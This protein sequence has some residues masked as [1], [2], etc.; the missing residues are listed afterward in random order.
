[1]DHHN[2]ATRAPSS[3]PGGAG[4]G[5]PPRILVLLAHPTLERSRNVARLAAAAAAHP[6][7]TVRDLYELYPDLLIDIDAEQAAVAEHAAICVLHPLHWYSAPAIVKQ[8]I[9]LVLEHGWAY[10]AGGDRCAGK[11]WTHAIAAGA[12]Q[13]AYAAQGPNGATLRQL[14]L[15]FEATA[16]LCG[17][18]FVEPFVM[19]GTHRA[20]DAERDAASKAFA[21]WLDEL[22]SEG[23][24]VS[25]ATGPGRQ[26]EVGHAR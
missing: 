10:G 24:R 4:H 8:W 15:P 25:D 5:A 18:H 23:D 12:P 6:R 3:A 14:L 21:A 9:D 17:M 20:T 22:A 11:T 1:M 13:M 26:T 7:S 2:P 19:Y 16:R